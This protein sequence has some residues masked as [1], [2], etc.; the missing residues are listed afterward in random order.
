VTVANGQTAPVTATLT[1][2][3]S[4]EDG[5]PDYCE[6]NGYRDGFGR[7][8]APDPNL[9]DTDEDG[10]SDYEEWNDPDYEEWNDPDYDPLVFEERYGPLET[11]REFLLGA[12][13]GEWGADDHDNI[14]YL[15]GWVASGV[16]VVGDLRDIAA[17]ISRGDLV[18]TGLNLAALIP[19]SKHPD[20]LPPQTTPA[21]I[22]PT[23]AST[24]Q[25]PT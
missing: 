23:T 22:T 13:L 16:V 3:D 21:A 11:G 8:H 6:E 19:V 24:T 10:H 1:Y 25:T 2:E 5:L 18:G 20:L 15:G 14:Y 7:W 12:V 17:A 9:I 4:D